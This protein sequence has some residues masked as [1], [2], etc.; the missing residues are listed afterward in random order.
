MYSNTSYWIKRIAG[1]SKA[2]VFIK[3]NLNI[4]KCNVK[5]GRILIFIVFC[6]TA[7]YRIHVTFIKLLVTVNLFLSLKCFAVSRYN[8]SKRL[9]PNASKLAF[10]VRIVEHVTC[11]I[12]QKLALAILA[13]YNVDN[14]TISIN[15]TVYIAH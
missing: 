3:V 12:L 1:I 9:A 10:G 6:Q 13:F 15:D 14:V 5:F 2:Q 11:R 7:E 4:K 8:T